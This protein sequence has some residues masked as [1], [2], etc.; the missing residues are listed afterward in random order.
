MTSP[1]GPGSRVDPVAATLAPAAAAG[2]D[3]HCIVIGAGPAGA[4][5]AFRLA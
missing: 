3:W 4:A 5:V 2:I 1:P